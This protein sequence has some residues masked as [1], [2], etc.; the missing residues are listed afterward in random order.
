MITKDENVTISKSLTIDGKKEE[1]ENYNYTGTM[2]VNNVTVTV[3]NVEF[4][5]GQVYK[6]KNTGGNAKITINNCTFDGDGMNAYAINIGGSNSIVIEDVTVKDYGY[7]ML[8]V[9]SS[10]TSLTV[11]GVDIQNCYYGLKV[12]YSNGVTLENVTMSDDVT[13]GIYD[14]NYGTKT[15]AVKNRFSIYSR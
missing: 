5:K 8:Q 2:T 11:K 1:K 3:Q 10:N 7:G 14:S 9:P 12:D 15:Y 13:I 6:N 4:V